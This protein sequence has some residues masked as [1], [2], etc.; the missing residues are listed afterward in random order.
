MCGVFLY[1]RVMK[2]KIALCLTMLLFVSCVS[3]TGI[4]TSPSP[5]E[6]KSIQKKE[7]QERLQKTM[8]E[9]NRRIDSLISA[10]DKR[11][12]KD[13]NGQYIRPNW[14]STSGTPLYYST[15]KRS[16]RKAI[17]AT[18][19]N[20]G[21]ALG[22]ELNGEGI[23]IGIWDAGHIFA[24]HDEFTGGADFFGYQVPIE[25][26]D[27]TAADVRDFHPTAVASII[28]AKGMLDNENFEITGIAPKLAKLYSYDWDNDI[29][30]IFE[31][32][33]TNNNTDF[34]LSNHSY[35]RPL[36]DKNGEIIADKDIGNYSLWS[37]LIDQI[38][39]TYPYYLHVVAGG[40]GGNVEYDSQQVN[41]LDQLTGSTTA[42]N[43]LTV[44]SFS[45]D[46][47]SKNFT[48]TGF[49]SAG[50]TND[51]RIKPEICAAGQ[52]LSAASWDNNNPERTDNYVATSG[53]SFA[54]PG[55]VAGVALLQQFYKSSHNTFMRGATAKALLCHTADDI[56]SW[57]GLDISGPDVKTGYGALNMEK[58]V[59]IIQKDIKEKNTIVEFELNNNTTKTLYFQVLEEGTITATLSWYDPHAEA[60][61]TATLVNDLDLRIYQDETTYFPWKLPTTAQQAATV[62]G[63]NRVDNLE[64]IKISKDLGGVYKVEVSHKGTLE[65]NSQQ[66]S[67]ILSGPGI[68]IASKEALDNI[69]KDGFLVSPI[70]ANE[71]FIITPL[72]RNIAF[73]NVRLLNLQGRE[74]A[75]VEKTSFTQTPMRFYVNHITTGRYM[76]AIET[77]NGQ[78]FKSVMI[79]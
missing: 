68:A 74:V 75:H 36:K 42:K 55:T 44:G 35:G 46:N 29:T 54:A 67:L 77:Q 22:L 69:R 62:L 31:Q 65:N 6:K 34:I 61:A 60:K 16:A 4:R 9:Q 8:A 21:G 32:L 51:Y 47:N 17:K 18:A 45:M 71:Y 25:I 40:N 53:T 7:L 30:E 1:L 24:S 63:D 39:Y 56:T 13:K 79:R 78:I 3:S 33:Q 12:R 10:K 2:N 52:L 64:Q 38:T 19:L 15:N 20:T 76:L 59:G 57:N 27:S 5:Q 72:K 58:A 73:R 43:A 66:A 28:I 26:A 41:G 37:S 48:P 49:S 11:L 23:H 50:P 14:V 70:P